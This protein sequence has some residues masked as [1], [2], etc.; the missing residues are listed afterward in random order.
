MNH[1][2]PLIHSPAMT[3]CCI[4]MYVPTRTYSIHTPVHYSVIDAVTAGVYCMHTVPPKQC[5]LC[6]YVRI[7]RIFVIPCRSEHI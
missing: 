3:Q 6:T 1:F 7:Y 5:H 4:A 2:F